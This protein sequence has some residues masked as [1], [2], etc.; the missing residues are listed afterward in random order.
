MPPNAYK[1]IFCKQT[2]WD[3]NQNGHYFTYKR[4]VSL[5]ALGMRFKTKNIYTQNVDIYELP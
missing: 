1:T 2:P 3:K 5:F 4:T